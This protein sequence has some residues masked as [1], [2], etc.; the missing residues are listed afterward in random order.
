MSEFCSPCKRQRCSAERKSRFRDLQRWNKSLLLLLGVE[1]VCERLFDQASWQSINAITDPIRCFVTAGESERIPTDWNPN[2]DCYVCQ[3]SNYNYNNSNFSPCDNSTMQHQEHMEQPQQHHS[4]QDLTISPNAAVVANELPTNNNQR[5]SSSSSL[6]SL[7]AEDHHHQP[8]ISFGLTEP[9][10]DAE[11]NTT[12]GVEFPFFGSPNHANYLLAQWQRS[13]AYSF[14][15]LLPIYS[16]CATGLP[17]YCFADNLLNNTIAGQNV[18]DSGASSLLDYSKAEPLHGSCDEPLDLTVHPRRNNASNVGKERMSTTVPAGRSSTT[19]SYSNSMSINGNKRSYS[20]ADLEAAVLDI[21]SGKLGTRRASVIYGV[22]RSTLRNKI[23]KLEAACNVAGAGVGVGFRSER[24]SATTNNNNNKQSTS[25]TSLC[26][27]VSSGRGRLLAGNANGKT[28]KVANCKSSPT[29]TVVSPNQSVQDLAVQICAKQLT[30]ALELQNQTVMPAAAATTNGRF[31]N[32]TLMTMPSRSML[33]GLVGLDA[34]RNATRHAVMKAVQE[35]CTNNDSRAADHSSTVESRPQITTEATSDGAGS[36][37]SSDANLL[38][39]ANAKKLRR[40]RGQYRKYDKNA[41]ALA[42]QSVRRGEMSVHKAGSFYG[43]PHSTLEYKV[44]ERNLLRAKKQ[45]Q[46]ETASSNNHNSNNKKAAEHPTATPCTIAPRPN[47][48]TVENCEFIYPSNLTIAENSSTSFGQTATEE[49][50][51]RSIKID[52]QQRQ[53]QQPDSMDVENSAQVQQQ[54]L[55]LVQQSSWR[56][57]RRK[58]STPKK[59]TSVDSSSI[60]DYAFVPLA[61]N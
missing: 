56:K 15:P 3:S 50:D 45:Q 2:E 36:R 10:R 17:P 6:L 21:R 14:Y 28:S 33:L 5:R 51:D 57:M 26:G 18:V 4:E 42:V 23:H 30:S 47:L 49:I 53:Q 35:L 12:T 38:D 8:M 9:N 31:F 37:S 55:E 52:E 59:I 54:P 25:A 11:L 41:L 32:P 48:E 61:T 24:R 40:K 7:Q 29:R 16:N 13:F 27:E 46:A 58:K 20:K 39:E 34:V 19:S 44:K 22:P 43:V 1:Q 60:V